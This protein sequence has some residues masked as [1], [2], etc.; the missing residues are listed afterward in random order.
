M[1]APRADPALPRGVCDLSAFLQP[2]ALVHGPDRGGR[3]RGLG[4]PQELRRPAARPAFLERDQEQRGHGERLAGN[5]GRA[6]GRACDVLQSAPQGCVARARHS[7][8]ADVDHAHRGG[9]DVA[10]P[11]QPG[12]GAGQLVHR[13]GRPRA[14]ELVRLDRDGYADAHPRRIVAMDAVRLHHRLCAAAGAAAGG[15]RGGHRRWRQ[16]A[17]HVPLRHVAAPDAGDHIRRSLPWG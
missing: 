8:A 13:G 9:R 5:S 7:G 14:A 2:A 6:R 11:A 12:L 4:R 10:G 3:H 15:V 1:A 17:R 16:A